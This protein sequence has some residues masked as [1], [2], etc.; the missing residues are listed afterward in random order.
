GHC[1]YFASAM[2]IGLRIRGVPARVVG[3]YLGADRST[4]GKEFVVS[5]ARAHMWV[6]AHVPGSGWTTFDP[7]PPEGRV[8][9]SQ[10]QGLLRDGWERMVL[11]WD[12]LVIGF[13]ISDQADFVV[14]SRE[15]LTTLRGLLARYWQY[16]TTALAVAALVG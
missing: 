10:W 6:E 8:P 13:D 3:G 7:T 2:V 15:L 11:T 4:F 9:P 14:W 16:L 12:A 1:E 5:E